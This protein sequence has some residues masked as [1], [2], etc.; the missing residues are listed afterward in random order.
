MSKPPFGSLAIR[1]KLTLAAL[2]PLVVVLLLVSLAASYLINA[3]VVGEAQKKVSN[4][5]NSAREILRNQEQRVQDVIRFTAHS[6]G[7]QDALVKDDRPRILAELDVIRRREGLDILN[8]TDRQGRIL[9]RSANP[10][11]DEQAPPLAELPF[12]PDVLNGRD[13]S[14]ALLIEVDALLMEGSELAARARIA[15]PGQGPSA[16][17]NRGLFLIGAAAAHDNNGEV[18]GCLYGGVLLSGNLPLVDR[19][20]EIV[21]GSETFEGTEIGGATIFLGD[22]RVATTIRLNNGQRAI[23]TRVS[24]E[25]AE[26]VLHRSKTWLARAKVVDRWYLTAYEPILDHAGQPV[27]ALYV[28]LL[29]APFNNLKKQ[30]WFGLFAL[31]LIGGGVGYLLSRE[32]SRH[33][34]KPILQLASGAERVA[35][36]E[37][38]ILLP[39]PGED[40][41]GQLTA[42]FNRMTAALKQRDE[43]LGSLTRDLE[44]QVARRTAQLEEKGL[45]LMRAQEELLRSEKLAAIGSLAAGVAHEINNPAAII[46]GNVEIL[47]MEI[48]AGESGREE[49]EEI[50]KQ[51]ERVSLITESM[52]AFAREQT[53]HPEQVRVNTL[54][55]EILAQISHQVPLRQVSIRRELAASLPP[56]V[57]DGERLRQVFTNILINALQAM[58][59]KGALSISSHTD[60]G[61]VE[62]RITDTGPG[63]SSEIREKIFNPFFTTKKQGTGLGLSVSYGIIKALGGSIAVESAVGRGSTF[64]VS[65]PVS[66]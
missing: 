33:L 8:F 4:D 47:L 56:V 57:A 38:D 26:A 9:V 34:T 31:L 32:I 28:G 62:I 64:I 1:G 46:R 42:A 10:D 21:Y 49:A 53:I 18:L 15:P 14:G 37:R 2:T 12:L 65:L 5:L 51:T 60:N 54:I 25:V 58:D 6:T 19:I 45:Q 27:G 11:A 24:K 13:Y 40:E 36:G 50:L 44:K 48:P 17:E 41:I 30:A 39:L 35:A 59:G 20:R 22:I 63:I 52:L 3:W 16:I 61:T 7:L 66:P 29:E 43:E 23:G 55:E